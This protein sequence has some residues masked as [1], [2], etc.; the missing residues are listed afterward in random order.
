MVEYPPV[1]ELNGGHTLG[2]AFL[3]FLACLSFALQGT[4]E[5]FIP[6][7]NLPGDAK[8]VDLPVMVKGVKGI[9]SIWL[10]LEFDPSKL[11]AEGISYTE[12]TKGMIRSDNI[13]DGRVLIAMAGVKPRDL[14]GEL[15][16]IKFRLLNTVE[17]GDLLRIK[18][19]RADFDEGRI[20]VRVK[21]GLIKVGKPS[22][23]APVRRKAAVWGWMKAKGMTCCRRSTA[24][25]GRIRAL[26]DP[27]GCSWN[28]RPWR[29]WCSRG[30]SISR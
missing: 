12:L 11:A 2:E 7:I 22:G 21:D 1:K 3:T 6:E 29:S 14:E 23:F 20:K 17:E 27:A 9:V 28:A 30:R 4:G 18:V 19:V 13:G 10:E 24:G 15:L 16:R 26:R 8:S 5:L 25:R